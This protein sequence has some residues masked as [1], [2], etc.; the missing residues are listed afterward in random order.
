MGLAEP[1]LRE[2][3]IKRKERTGSWACAR[4]PVCL[5]DGRNA[6]SQP[7]NVE[8]EEIRMRLERVTDSSHPIYN[9]ALRLYRMSFPYHE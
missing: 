6:G 7:E 1:G 4:V 9:E 5:V 2:R 8:Q 3:W